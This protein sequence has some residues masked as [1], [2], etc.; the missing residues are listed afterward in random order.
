M[1]DSVNT[2]RQTEAFF[3]ALEERPYEHDF[4]QTLRRLDCLFADKPRIGQA[5]RPADEAIR[6]AQEPS[7]SFAPSTLAA[8]KRANGD[9]PARLQVRFFGLLGPNGPLPMHLTEY[10]MERLLHGGATTFPR[11]L[12]VIHHRFLAL[13]YRAWAQAQL[14]A[15]LDR[16]HQDR[17]TVYVGSLS[18]IGA[19]R[20][21]TRDAIPDFAK[22][23]YSGLLV[24]H[25]RNS[26]GLTALLAG[27]F[28]VPIRVEEFVGHWLSL[29][30]GDRTRLGSH[31]PNAALGKGTV[32]GSRIW[33]HQHKFRIWVGPLSLAQYESFLPGGSA[34]AKLVAWV[35]QYLCFELEWDAR[36]VL[37][38][39]QVPELRLG[40]MVRLGWTTW[41]GRFSR[42]SD[43]QDL[44]LDAE[45]LMSPGRTAFSTIG[46]IATA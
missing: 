35:R 17:F 16:P 30:R 24:Q 31:A 25:V 21:R 43:A 5:L 45:G 39:E 41:L 3:R 2:L 28:K 12:D 11:F 14:T 34:I 6:L 20:L 23:F 40:K 46:P 13:F 4:F 22:L 1:R 29:P 38:R 15:S 27:Y 10:A 18:G 37:A 9:V 32:A 36:L 26:D 44:T 8:F 42:G 33:D 19:T 7:L